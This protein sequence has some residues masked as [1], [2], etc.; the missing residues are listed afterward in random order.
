MSKKGDVTMAHYQ[1]SHSCGHSQEHQLFGHGKDREKK[2]DWLATTNCK[3]CYKAR[4]STEPPDVHFRQVT[5]A[6]EIIVLNSF[7]AKDD[8]KERE[9]RFGEF[10]VDTG[11]IFGLKARP[12]WG[13]VIH[14]PKLLETELKWIE[15]QG[16]K[17]HTPENLPYQI[18]ALAAVVEG[19]P[20]VGGLPHDTSAHNAEIGPMFGFGGDE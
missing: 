13:L 6:V 20:D 7:G 16:W 8:L 12:G 2:L 3:E 14:S 4:R 18:R 10:S 17:L 11:D 19:R 15:T 1:V 5:D 9:Y